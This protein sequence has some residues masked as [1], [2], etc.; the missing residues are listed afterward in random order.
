MG[1]VFAVEQNSATHSGAKTETGPSFTRTFLVRTDC[2][3][4]ISTVS[5]YVGIVYNSAHPESADSFME[6]FETSVADDSGLLYTVK[7]N[8]KPR[9]PD[10]QGDDPSEEPGNVAG[11]SRQSVWGASSGVSTGPVFQDVIG[12]IISNTAGDP[13][14]G[15]SKEF[16]DFK[17]TLTQYYL[18]H[19][20]WIGLAASYTNTINNAVWNGGANQT[21][22]CQGCSAKLSTESVKDEFD[23]ETLTKFWEVSWDFAYREETWALKVWDVG[24]SQKV[25]AVTKLPNIN[26]GEKA[27]IK[28]Y[29]GKSLKSPVALKLGIAKVSG[30]A[31]W[32]KPDEIEFQIYNSND[33]GAAFGEIFT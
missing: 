13:L 21:W 12:D 26:G 10:D 6:S 25:D 16:A 14:E 5:G 9:K 31:G 28:G 30:D 1:L 24:L 8:Y 22:K 15:L 20:E 33:F 3:E 7:L 4:N 17:L 19:G 11:L 27:N 23:V 2:V 29:D 32:P 18:T